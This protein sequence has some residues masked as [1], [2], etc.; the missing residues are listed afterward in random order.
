MQLGIYN[1]LEVLRFTS[2][3]AYLGNEKGE[4][5]LLP[6]RYIPHNLNV[7]DSI[8]VFIYN[9]SEDRVIATTEEPLIF[10]HEFAYLSVQDTNEYGAF[11]DMGLMK[12]LFVPYKEQTVKMKKGG[13]YLVYMY[14]D[15]QS[16][17]L[18]GTAKIK[19]HLSKVGREL[20]QGEKVNLLICDRTELGQK[21][22][23]NQQYEGL[24]F[25][26][27]LTRDVQVGEQLKGYIYYIRTDGKLDISLSPIGLE[28]FD[29]HENIIL[30]YLA[31]H[32]NQM[33]FTDRT[34]PEDIRTHFGMSKKSFKK[35]LGALYKAKKIQLKENKVLLND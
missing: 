4:D 23:V 30:E 22:I 12:D 8:R 13:I 33:F 17:R 16:Q 18:V 31:Q 19:N 7:G 9:D 29:Y 24:I 14:Q 27:Q 1:D 2:V 25:E 15:M 6:N 20:S 32:N 10:L 34:S 21:V 26:D 35:A 11:L 3:G 5:V 28:K